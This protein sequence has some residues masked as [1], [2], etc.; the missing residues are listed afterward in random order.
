VLEVKLKKEGNE[1]TLPSNQLIKYSQFIN[2]S[3]LLY[4]Y[5]YLPCACLIISSISLSSTVLDVS[6]GDAL[7]KSFV[8]VLGVTPAFTSHV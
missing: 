5:Y 2:L 6:I 8:A 7:L 3:V 1:L 4:L